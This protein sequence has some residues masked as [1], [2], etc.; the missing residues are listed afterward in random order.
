MI[1]WKKILSEFSLTVW[2]VGGFSA[3]VLFGRRMHNLDMDLIDYFLMKWLEKIIKNFVL[4]QWFSNR[5]LRNFPRFFTKFPPVFQSNCFHHPPYFLKTN[6]SLKRS[7]FKPSPASNKKILDTPLAVSQKF[8]RNTVL[9]FHL[10]YPLA[11][12]NW[13]PKSI[14]FK[15]LHKI[16][17]DI[18]PT[19]LKMSSKMS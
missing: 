5:V 15:I 6:T 14:S 16:I 18:Q 19:C 10:Y 4:K 8:L 9:K 1:C 3:R 7:C 11:L 2:M 17:T 13:T 12:K